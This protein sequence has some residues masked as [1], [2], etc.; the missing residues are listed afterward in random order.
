VRFPDRRRLYTAP[1]GIQTF[2]KT[3]PSLNEVCGQSRRVIKMI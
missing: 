1:R 3:H 2:G